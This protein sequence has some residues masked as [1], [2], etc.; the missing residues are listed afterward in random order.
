MR[1]TV[2]TRLI[3]HLSGLALV[4]CIAGILIFPTAGCDGTGGLSLEPLT[5]PTL[6]TSWLQN[7]Q[8]TWVET[9]DDQETYRFFF[10]NDSQLLGVRL[11]K[12]VMQNAIESL[13]ATAN[14]EDN[15]VL[16]QLQIGINQEAR[17]AAFTTVRGG[18]DFAVSVY[19]KIISGSLSIGDNLSSTTQWQY[20]IRA[21]YQTSGAS[22]QITTQATRQLTGTA[23]QQHN[24]IAFSSRT[25]QGTVTDGTD[26][27]PLDNTTA[28]E[29]TWT[30]QN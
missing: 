3:K 9:Q 2:S 11:V 24:Q 6:D 23:N 30:L 12:S 1:P 17:F 27:E 5:E 8:Q 4:I 14:S 16:D 15:Q 22:P 21:V 13:G 25:I 10:D 28:V 29:I 7:I 19:I 18:I 26:S 20:E